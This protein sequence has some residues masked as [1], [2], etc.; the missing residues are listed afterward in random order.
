LLNHKLSDSNKVFMVAF[1]LIAWA[2]PM[3]KSRKKRKLEGLIE[4]SKALAIAVF[5]MGRGVGAIKSRYASERE[6]EM[7]RKRKLER[8]KSKL[9]RERDMAP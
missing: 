2:L 3:P 1:P 5:T 7:E 9:D 8:N 6:K 4:F